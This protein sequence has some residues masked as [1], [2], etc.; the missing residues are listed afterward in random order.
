MDKLRLNV[1]QLGISAIRKLH[2]LFAET[3]T[4]KTWQLTN[5]EVI[6]AL[7]KNTIYLSEIDA[8]NIIRKYEENEVEVSD[9]RV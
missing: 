8:A 1:A 2:N 9:F 6:V 3:D 5:E 4:K 7:M